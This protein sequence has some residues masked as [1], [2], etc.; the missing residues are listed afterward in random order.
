[1]QNDYEKEMIQKQR[2]WYFSFIL[3]VWPSLW[4]AHV[5]HQKTGV[6]I[7]ASPSELFILAQ[8]IS[9]S[10][11]FKCFLIYLL[12]LLMF[13]YITYLYRWG[14]RGSEILSIWSKMVNDEGGSC[15]NRIL[16][17][18][19]PLSYP[20]YFYHLIIGKNVAWKV[21]LKA[22]HLIIIIISS[23]RY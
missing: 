10:L 5:H 16:H 9:A 18:L 2:E 22:E 13:I 1:M 15:F 3:Q 14:N 21:T 7:P 17:Q 8:F 6:W 11:V 12:K 23:L 4:K 19:F 20:I